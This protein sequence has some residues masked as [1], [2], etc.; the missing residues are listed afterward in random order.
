M[1]KEAAEMDR[2]RLRID[3]ES[4]L[5]GVPEFFQT[6]KQIIPMTFGIHG[7]LRLNCK[8]IQAVG[9]LRNVNLRSTRTSGVIIINPAV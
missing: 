4:F 3:D 2:V 8:L 5:C 6:L 7:D 1:A 9:V